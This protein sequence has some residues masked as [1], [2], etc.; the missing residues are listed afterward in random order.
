[1][2]S[3][4]FNQGQNSTNHAKSNVKSVI[5]K[6]NINTLDGVRAIACLSVI[7]YHVHYAAF[8]SFDLHFYSTTIGKF[9]Y[10]LL[11][12]GWS[13]VTLFFVLSGF[14]LF[15][16]YAKSLLF[17]DQWPSARSFYWRRI[18]RIVPGYYIS[19][20]ILIVIR[21]P[22]YLQLDHL[23]SLTLFLTFLMDAPAT[24]QQINGPFW[25]LAIEWQ[26]Y[27]LLPIIA[28]IFSLLIRLGKSPRQRFSLIICCLMAMLVWGLGTRYFGRYYTLHPDETFLVDRPILN[29]ILLVTYGA[30]G[31]YF[32]D[33][34]IGMLVCTIYIFTRKAASDNKLSNILNR[35]SIPLFILGI[36]P[37][38]FVST[39]IAFAPQLPI[40]QY[41]G[42][43][44]WLNEIGYSLGFGLCLTAILFGPA[45]LKRP[46]EWYPL[47]WIGM[48]SYSAYIWHL[49][50]LAIFE[51]FVYPLLAHRFSVVYFSYWGWI[52]FLVIPFSY[53]YYR[54][55]EYPGI[56][57]ANKSRQ[58][59][60]TR[61]IS[62]DNVR[63]WDSL[64]VK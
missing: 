7:A 27:M 46:F 24:F 23:K 47:R 30:S 55:I 62:Q 31:K 14:L 10:N 17:E 3:L 48:V 41:I 20:A 57:L 49:P 18:L 63:H 19:L 12:S 38:L 21:H 64:T 44:S 25:T 51:I 1:M 13:G 53:L 59:Q 36:L 6:S 50:I 34:A 29:N 39:W 5:N 52:V 45:S 54:F 4:R 42:A 2:V 56:K 22:E 11:M 33:F 32:E 28:L 60:T 61:L 43:H 16:P 26:Y 9:I 58:K 35:C 8:K 15:I 37:P 40:K